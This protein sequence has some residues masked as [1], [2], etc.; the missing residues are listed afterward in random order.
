M[1]PC[2]RCP[3]HSHGICQLGKPLSYD[4]Q[5]YMCP[6][7]FAWSCTCL[8]LPSAA[9]KGKALTLF[10]CLKSVRVKGPDSPVKLLCVRTAQVTGGSQPCV[11]ALLLLGSFMLSSVFSGHHQPTW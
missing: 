11:H 7:L 2:G 8:N 9:T 10:S 6:C 5:V 1:V 3:A 4:V